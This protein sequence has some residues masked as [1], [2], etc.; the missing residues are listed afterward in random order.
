[1]SRPA[2]VVGGFDR[3]NCA[4]LERGVATN[5][6]AKIRRQRSAGGSPCNP[7]IAHL[8]GTLFALQR[9]V[10]QCHCS[11]TPLARRTPL[12]VPSVVHERIDRSRRHWPVVGRLL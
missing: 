12:L 9:K 2:P 3:S 10:S 1:T 4:S 11:L 8:S 6:F 7:R 5:R